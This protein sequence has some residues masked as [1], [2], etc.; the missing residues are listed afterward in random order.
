MIKPQIQAVLFDLD[1]TVLDTANDL[2]AALNYMLDKYQRPQIAASL[3]RPVASDGVKGLLELGFAAELAHFDFDL[4]RAEFL[5]YYRNNL[6]QHSCFYPDMELFLSALN[7]KAI[8]WGIVT[9][10]PI[11][12]TMQLLPSFS[13]FEHCQ[14]VVGGDSLPERKPHPAPLFFACEALQVAP[15]HCVYVGDAQRDITAGNA[16]GMETIVA[17]WGYI[18][19]QQQ[20]KQ[21]Q[22]DH[23]ATSVKHLSDIIFGDDITTTQV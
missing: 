1:G 12:L 15:Q 22:A 7:A 9:N 13:A 14:V 21:W 23:W 4:L 20:C 6:A 5:D 17:Q 2:G 18:S 8:P 3:F 11:G 16:A 10:K 19:D